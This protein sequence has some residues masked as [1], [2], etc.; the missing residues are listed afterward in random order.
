MFS[1]LTILLAILGLGFLVFIHE[2]GHYIVARRVG[3]KVEAFSIGFGKPIFSWEHKGV[4]WQIC[5]LPFGGYV[6]IA[7]MQKEGNLE[8]YEVKGGFFASKPVDRIKVA[9]MGPLVNIVFAFVVFTLLW[10]SGGR[11]KPFQEFTHRIGW[12]D[13]ASTLYDHGV[14]PGDEILDYD[15]KPFKGFK[16][17]MLASVTDDELSRIR[18]YKINYLQDEKS[19]FDY[20]LRTY[21]DPRHQDDGLTTVGILS[22]ASYLIYDR[23]AN[24]QENPLFPGSPLE[25]SGFQYGDRIFWI[26]GDLVFSVS[27]LKSLMSESTVFLTFKRNGQ[28]FHSKIPRVKIDDFHLTK[29]QREDLEDWRYEAN[30][31]EKFS[32]LYFVPYLLSYDNVVEGTLHFIDERD[33]ERVFTQCKRCSFFNPLRKG[34]Q[35]LAIDGKPIATSDELLSELQTHHALMIVQRDAEAFKEISWKNADNHFD[36][37]FRPSDL[38]NIIQS[39]GTNSPVAQSGNL[40]LLKTITPKSIL[41]FAPSQAKELVLQN[42][43]KEK[44]AIEKLDSSEK[45]AD[46]LKQLD[47]EAN[48][49]YLGVHLQDRKVRYNPNPFI[50][51]GS[52]FD[53]TIHTLTSLFTGYLNPKW[54][55]GPIGIV[56]VVQRSWMLGVKEALFWMGVISL[57]LGILN[58]LPIPVLDGGHICF[59]LFEMVTKRRL[60]AK[61]MERLIIPFVV[62]LIGMIVFVTYHDLSRIFSRFF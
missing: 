16:D 10:F 38:E 22:P 12:V 23:F 24:Q 60:K 18:G 27:Q 33:Q 13:R 1:L 56:H 7:G 43:E 37:Y 44:K 20:T 34:D 17:L 59:S 61:T 50:L 2:L 53:E 19:P 51:F 28:I 39:I 15:G 62:L 6:K 47:Q 52:V 40:L 57:N 55:S 14:R 36:Q 41:D 29:S 26:D 3:M 46:L 9:I 45:R 58:L 4:K 21:E 42:L 31:S 5:C 11:E 49:P 8:P 25:N 48:Q 32:Q 54:L 35:I 30:I